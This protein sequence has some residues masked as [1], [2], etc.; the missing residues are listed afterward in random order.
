MKFFGEEVCKIIKKTVLDLSSK[1]CFFSNLVSLV[2]AK[3][4]IK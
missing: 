1:D 3:F 2:G 4:G